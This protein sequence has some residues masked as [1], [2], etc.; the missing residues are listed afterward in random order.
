MNKTQILQQFFAP[1]PR[2]LE[3]V[4][5]TELEAAGATDTE[6]VPGGAH[7]RGDW[8]TCYRV[9]LNSRVATRVLWRVAH[10]RYRAEPDIYRLAY[11]TTWPE[12]FDPHR[13]IRVYVTAIQS[14]LRSLEYITVHIK[15]AIVTRFLDDLGER[16]SVDTE[17]P[18][19]RIHAFFDSETVTLYL[20]TSGEP[21]F[22]RGFRR[23]TNEAPLKENLAAGILLLS[24]WDG[25]TPLLDP[26][27]GSGTILLEAAL[28]ALKIPPGSKRRFGFEKLKLH[29]PKLWSSIRDAARREQQ[30][31]RP[32]PIYGSDLHHR[33]ME[34]ARRNLQDAG[35][36]SAVKLKQADVL[37]LSA[38]AE[39]G[40]MV[41]N[42][43]YGIRIGD[44]EKLAA[45]YPKLGDAL[46]KN[47]SGWNCYILSAD[48]RLAK[49]IHLSASRR[50]PLFNGA[51]E[52]RLLEYRMVAGGMRKRAETDPE[53]E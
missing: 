45:F 35:F 4:L 9:N 1:C 23:S 42:P 38:P 5:I 49:L 52:C 30:P 47:F 50:I 53:Q 21:L 29:Q 11:E 14:P 26:M 17:L 20:D 51:L 25:E 24:G 12:W 39:S 13:T 44:Q 27:C 41:T 33:E 18:D 37:R 28:L 36:A 3:P 43:P 34:A 10:G 15:D 46:K 7:F 19:V 32:L 31:V 6:A 8:S 16:P 22:K 2:G 48:P 40:V